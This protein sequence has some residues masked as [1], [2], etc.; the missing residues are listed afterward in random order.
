VKTTDPQAALD[1]VLRALRGGD[2]A[3]G[4]ALALDALSTGYEHPLLLNLRALDHE[5]H[6]RFEAALADLRRAHALAPGDYGVLNAIGLCLMRMHRAREAV[7]SYEAALALQPAFAPAW[8]NLGA[9]LEQLGEPLR[10]SAAY[11]KATDFEPRNVQGWANQAWLAARRGDAEAARGLADRALAL[12]PGHPTAVLA[13]ASTELSEPDVAE[14]RLR[15]LL[16]DPTVGPFDRSVGLSQ[17]GDALDAQG[18]TAEAFAAYEQANALF[19]SEARPRFEA[20][21]QATAADSLAW[22]VAW[23][24]SL[25]RRQWVSSP[26]AA[27]EPSVARMHVFLVGFPRSGTTLAESALAGHPDVVSLEERNTLRAAVRAFLGDARDL[28]RL[29]KARDADLAPLRADYWASVREHGVQPEGKVFIDKNPFNTPK[30]PLIY[31]LFPD[32]RI[33]FAVRDPRD[34]VL[35]CFRRRFNLNPSTYELLDLRRAASLYDRTMT[36]ADLLWEKQDLSE[37]RLIY[38][39]LVH[40][41]EGELREVCD[42]IGVDWRPDLLDFAGRAREGGVASASSEQI[43]RGLY[44]EGVGQWRRYRAQMAAVEPVL[45]PWVEHFGYPPQ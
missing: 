9:A 6:G 34:V 40:D 11:A 2:M 21:G 30:L 22:L 35:S 43:S 15:A 29:A 8:F 38:E 17:L 32:A 28:S 37:H 19:Q 26:R 4:R 42:F 36:L 16:A 27:P 23:A 14:Q 7:A 5:D 3:R 39:R 25:D 33:L 13:L 24:R 1:G 20:P 44:G 12:Q 45:A 31:K 41:F 18:R 10:A